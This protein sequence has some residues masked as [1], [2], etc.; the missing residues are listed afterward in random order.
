MLDIVFGYSK[1]HI[2]IS[3]FFLKFGYISNKLM[4][5]SCTDASDSVAENLA[6]PPTASSFIL[7]T[8]KA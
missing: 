2:K 6:V 8:Q 7:K 4:Y 3:E 1:L 5:I